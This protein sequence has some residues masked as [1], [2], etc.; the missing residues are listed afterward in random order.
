MFLEGGERCIGM[1]IWVNVKQV[2]GEV[3]R[4]RECAENACVT[5]SAVNEYLILK[6]KIFYG[7]FTR[8]IFLKV[9]SICQLM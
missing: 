4:E 7:L 3:A 6:I 8:N 1:C 9:K 5:E 2:C